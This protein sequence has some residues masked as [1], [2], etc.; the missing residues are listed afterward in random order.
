MLTPKKF[1]DFVDSHGRSLHEINPGSP[2]KALSVD[3][4]L[5]AIDLLSD[6]QIAILGGDVLADSGGELSYTYENWHCDQMPGESPLDFVSRSQ[7]AAREFISS[8]IKRGTRNLFIVLV[9]SEL[10][11][12]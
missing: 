7:A 12:S 3:S 1:L 5:K 11:V 6:N 9:H 8:L 10:G 4:A 2:E